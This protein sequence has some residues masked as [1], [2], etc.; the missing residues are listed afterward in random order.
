MPGRCSPTLT[1]RRE[2][3]FRNWRVSKLRKD[4]R[5][6]RPLASVSPSLKHS[7]TGR[8]RTMITLIA[9][10][11]AVTRHLLESLLTKW[12][13]T[14]CTADNGTTAMQLL[15]RVSPPVIVML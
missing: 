6:F 9:E 13:H 7:F 12:G 5:R 11:D 8:P 4:R 2:R 15:E 10:D 3:C 14:V 1:N